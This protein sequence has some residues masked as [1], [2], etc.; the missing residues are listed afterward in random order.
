MLPD[1]PTSED[2]VEI[3]L[4]GNVDRHS[5]GMW[6]DTA[7]YQVLYIHVGTRK[8]IKDGELREDWGG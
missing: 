6:T 1:Q 4:M 7:E 8:C 3:K 2:Y 5:R